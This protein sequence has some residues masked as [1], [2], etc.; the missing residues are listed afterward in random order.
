M[1]TRRT[2]RL[3]QRGQSMAELLTVSLALV[4]LFLIMPLLG[5][6]LDMSQQAEMASR[7]VAFEGTVH[8]ARSLNGWTG[9]ARLSEDVRRR[10]FSR[11][12]AP[13]KTQDTVSNF[14]GDRNPV[15]TDPAG[16]AMIEDIRRDV[17]VNTQVDSKNALIGA[18]HQGAF[19]LPKDN[20]L[21]ATVTVKPRNFAMLQ[22]FDRLNLSITRRTSVL[23]DAWSARSPVDV[24][25]R[26][27]NADFVAYPILPLKLLGQTVGQL[28]V[29]VLDKG[30]SVGQVQPDIIPC[31]RL[32]GGC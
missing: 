22:P 21:N 6:H 18:V 16:N 5:N 30:M 19:Q 31:D 29:L 12:D 9:D 15:W 7:Y 24:A 10:F 26:V 4:P 25:T 11:S 32:Q 1:R 17:W 14:A 23:V 8:H 28:P 13:I 20:L 3:R 27:E 2:G